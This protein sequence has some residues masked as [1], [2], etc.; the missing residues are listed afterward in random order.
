MRQRQQDLDAAGA[1]VYA[2]SFEQP[3]RVRAYIRHHQVTFPVLADPSRAVYARYG[4]TRGPL[5][6]IYGPQV[7]WGYL[8]L[9]LRGRRT[10]IRGDTLQQGGDF[11]VDAQGILRFA[12]AGKD[13]FDRPSIDEL[14]GRLRP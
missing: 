2:V 12:H 8:R 6:R 10:H 14:I 5:W 13:S 9:F 7:A 3:S 4:M 11:V 1:A